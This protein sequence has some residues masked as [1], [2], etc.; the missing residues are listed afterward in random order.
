M[1]L[2]KSAFIKIK[3]SSANRRWEIHGGRVAHSDPPINPSTLK[4]LYG[5]CLPKNMEGRCI[6]EGGVMVQLPGGAGAIIQG[7]GE[8]LFRADLSKL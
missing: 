3:Q 2:L 6:T 7:G 1:A 8:E 4:H 5:Q